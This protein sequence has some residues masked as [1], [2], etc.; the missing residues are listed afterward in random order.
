M[1]A[2]RST[3]FFAGM[4][5]RLGRQR[6]ENVSDASS[7]EL[8]QDSASSTDTHVRQAAMQVLA[9]SDTS[10]MPSS[11]GAGGASSI[12][13]SDAGG[14]FD[15]SM[16]SAKTTVTAAL[17]IQRVSFDLLRMLETTVIEE[18]RSRQ[19]QRVYALYEYAGEVVSNMTQRRSKVGGGAFGANGGGEDD[20]GHNG[21]GG[22]ARDGGA[23]GGSPSTQSEQ[24]PEVG[25]S[26]RRL[27]APTL[28]YLESAGA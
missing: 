6:N 4:L 8:S 2:S 3:G 28:A 17:L 5:G 22:T 1:A 25:M 26:T 10:D 20:C 12:F 19:L 9:D 18:K 11:A 7:S 23:G 14:V 13:G 16:A 24:A 21:G 27:S 15:P